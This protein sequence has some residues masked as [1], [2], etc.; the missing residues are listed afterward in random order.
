MKEVPLAAAPAEFPSISNITTLIERFAVEMCP[1][2]F[3]RVMIQIIYKPHTKLI[4]S[5]VLEVQYGVTVIP[6]YVFISIRLLNGRFNIGNEGKC[7][8]RVYLLYVN[9]YLPVKV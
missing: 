3:V 6:F 2:G 9:Q 5:M 8:L 1:F 7:F 4:Q